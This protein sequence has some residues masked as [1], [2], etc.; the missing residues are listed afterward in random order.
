MKSVSASD[1]EAGTESEYNDSDIEG[2][3]NSN[4]DVVVPQRQPRSA[5]LADKIKDT[6]KLFK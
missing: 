2:I 5:V 6:R 1:E 3:V 4:N